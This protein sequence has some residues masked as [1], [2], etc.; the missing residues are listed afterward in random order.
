MT[1]NNLGGRERQILL[2]AA[3]KAIEARASGRDVESPPS[4]VPESLKVKRGVFVSLHKR[5]ALRGCIGYMKADRPLYDAV[6][7]A[8][9][10]SAFGDPRF[11]A[12]EPEEVPH[13]EIEISIL[14]SPA[15][16]SSWKEIVVGRHGIVLKKGVY[17]ALF[18]P[19]VA[20]ERGWDL[21]TTLDNLAMK[22]G[23]PSGEWRE[24]ASFEVFEALVF[25]ESE[26]PSSC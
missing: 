20:Q 22:A 21:E 7:D 23:L 18:L 15:P 3:R 14:T 5:G 11:P 6:V 16:V 12:V 19:Q 17:H 4:P 10:S 25:G 26:S 1:V 13:I 9:L 8:A 24:G 2:D